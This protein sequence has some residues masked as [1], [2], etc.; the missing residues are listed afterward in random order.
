M[1]LLSVLVS[2]LIIGSSPRTS[3]N[4]VDYSTSSTRAGSRASQFDIPILIGSIVVTFI[5]MAVAS[6][7]GLAAAIYLAEY[8]KPQVR[9]VPQ[10][11]ARDP[12]RHPFG[13]GRRVR[14]RDQPELRAEAFTEATLT[15]LLVAG[16]G[17]GILTIPL[18]RLRV[19][20]R[21]GRCLTR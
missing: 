16:I 7:L 17:V 3:T 10:A 21:A 18:V 11:D 20:G 12:G 15:N 6:P 4:Q 2:V 9:K 13:R 19:G 5:A 1:P 8:A 14:V